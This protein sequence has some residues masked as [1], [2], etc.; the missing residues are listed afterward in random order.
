MLVEKHS[1]R[2]HLIEP[3]DH[4]SCN[5]R[6]HMIDVIVVGDHP[7]MQQALRA[8]LDAQPDLKSSVKRPT[9]WGR[10]ISP[11]RFDQMSC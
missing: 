5:E 4:T 7:L 3:D 11:K 8:I 10:S 1:Q 9:A 6:T 2:E